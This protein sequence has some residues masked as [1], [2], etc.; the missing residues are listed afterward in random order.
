VKDLLNNAGFVAL[1]GTIFGGAGLKIIESWLGR[2]KERS[3]QGAEIREELRKEI[4]GLR[5]QLDKASAEEQRLEAQVEQWRE[6]YWS[7]RE[8]KQS[9][10]TELTIVMERLKAYERAIAKN[11]L[12]NPPTT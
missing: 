8:E 9:L 5:N 3:D 12:D 4:E 1:V 6:K 7:L 10:V 11:N 2:A